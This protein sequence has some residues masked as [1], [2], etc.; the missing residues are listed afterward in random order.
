[1]TRAQILA[2]LGA[3]CLGTVAAGAA[4]AADAKNGER[5][6]QRWCA[7]C[8]LVSD[9]QRQASTDAAPFATIAKMSGFSPEKIA[10]FLLDP[11][12]KM[13]SMSLTRREAEDLAA[14]IATF[15]K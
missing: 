14:Y 8:H 7:S 9:G 2:L 6:A 11:H 15:A 13:P 1:V 12:P 3:L 4:M 5:I 10:F